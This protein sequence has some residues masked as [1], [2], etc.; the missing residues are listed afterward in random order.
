M[1]MTICGPKLRAGLIPQP[2]N[3]IRTRCANITLAPSDSN[4]RQVSS[5]TNLG[6]G[7]QEDCPYEEEC[8][9]KLNKKCRSKGFTFRHKVG[10]QQERWGFGTIATGRKLELRRVHAAPDEGSSQHGSKELRHDVTG[11]IDQV[12]RED[13]RASE[14]RRNKRNKNLHIRRRVR[15][16][17]ANQ[18]E[19]ERHCGINM[20]TRVRSNGVDENGNGEAKGNG[21]TEEKSVVANIILVECVE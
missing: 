2:V 11:S 14:G 12:C 1:I 10:A 4:R 15:T 7:S 9:H 8:A 3:G 20:T 5:N 6:D 19:C 17:F 16:D 13:E 18:P 21:N